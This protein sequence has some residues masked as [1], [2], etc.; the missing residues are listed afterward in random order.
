MNYYSKSAEDGSYLR[1]SPLTSKLS[2]YVI[3]QVD[4][5]SKYFLYRSSPKRTGLEIEVLAA[6]P[7]DDAAFQMSLLLGL[8]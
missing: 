3:S 1:I 2:Q 4:L 6:I 5:T 8:E 7:D